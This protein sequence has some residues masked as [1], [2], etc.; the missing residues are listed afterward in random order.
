MGGVQMNRR[1]HY[2]YVLTQLFVSPRGEVASRNVAVTFNLFE[3]E[4]LVATTNGGA[5]LL[6]TSGFSD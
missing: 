3:A 6:S 2:V 1:T 4:A 5:A